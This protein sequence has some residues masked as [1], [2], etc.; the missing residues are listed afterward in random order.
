MRNGMVEISGWYRVWLIIRIVLILIHLLNEMYLQTVREDPEA[1]ANKAEAAT[2]GLVPRIVA[3]SHKD[4][5]DRGVDM[6]LILVRAAGAIETGALHHL[7]T[8]KDEANA[9]VILTNP[10]IN[11]VIRDLPAVG[12]QSKSFLPIVVHILMSAI[13]DVTDTVEN[14]VPRLHLIGVEMRHHQNLNNL[15]ASTGV[16]TRNGIARP[17]HRIPTPLIVLQRNVLRKRARKRLPQRG[18][19]RKAKN[20]RAVVVAAATMTRILT[21]KLNERKRRAKAR[22]KGSDFCLT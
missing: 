7:T 9:V 20:I 13:Q 22:R 2:A 6:I 3:D 1:L 14:L 15:A 18:N 10:P 19:L 16:K 12:L 11:G 17:I 8:T 21:T 4:V 5:Q